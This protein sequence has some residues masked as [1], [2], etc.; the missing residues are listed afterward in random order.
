MKEIKI[1]EIIREWSHVWPLLARGVSSVHCSKMGYE[2]VV[3][4]HCSSSIVKLVYDEEVEISGYI[5]SSVERESKY[6][7]LAIRIPG[8]RNI[9][10]FEDLINTLYIEPGFENKTLRVFKDGDSWCAVIGKSFTNIEASMS[11]WGATPEEA[12]KNLL[13]QEVTD[14]I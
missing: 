11:G 7:R 1:S 6:P 14:G 10:I 12:V 2:M 8:H 5:K 9:W 3:F 4:L 13:K